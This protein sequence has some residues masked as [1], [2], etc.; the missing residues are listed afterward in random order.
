L[1]FLIVRQGLKIAQR[2]QDTFGS[3]LAYGLTFL[4]G[5]Q[6]FINISMNMGIAPVVGLPLPLMSYGGSSV[7]VTF[8][9][10]GILVNIDRTRNVF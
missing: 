2:T 8:I 6:V 5:L 10:L 4:L 3:L 7:L 1:Y 9:A